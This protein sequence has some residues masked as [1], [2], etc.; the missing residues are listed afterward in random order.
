MLKAIVVD[1]EPKMR[2]GLT[3]IISWE[4]HGFT[5]CGTAENGRRALELMEREQPQLIVTDIRMPVLG[6]LDL[7]MEAS[8]RYDC[9]FI[10]I[11][12]YG[13][14]EYAQRALV[15][16]AVDYL[17]KPIDEDQLAAALQRSRQRIAARTPFPQQPQ[18]EA[19]FPAKGAV[20][21]VMRYVQEHY[22]EP[23]TIKSI[24]AKV[25]L[26]PN[27]LGQLFKKQTGVYFNDYVHTVRIGE[28][29]KRLKST[30]HK[31]FDVAVSVGYSDVDYFVQQFK[32][33]VGCPPSGYRE[34]L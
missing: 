27:Y 13:E 28:A 3:K 10:V 21:E 29:K 34:K 26:N 19:V 32:K 30:T 33:I 11:S 9:Q 5:L 6:G 8:G 22:W 31:I 7:I 20:E 18:E 2:E 24:A 17:L 15:Y 25:Y 1:D 16:G 23:L 12:G 4:A 14:F